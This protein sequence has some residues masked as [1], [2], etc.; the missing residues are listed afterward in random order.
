MLCCF[1]N[2][3]FRGVITNKHTYDSNPNTFSRTQTHTHTDETLTYTKLPYKQHTHFCGSFCYYQENISNFARETRRINA[4]R[5]YEFVLLQIYRYEVYVI[6]CWKCNFPPLRPS[7]GRLVF[8]SVS[9]S[10]NIPNML[11]Y[12]FQ[13]SYRS[14]LSIKF[15]AKTAY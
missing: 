10:V 4:H 2:N 7:A 11:P 6:Y 14:T 12:I 3:D 1:Q 13:R 8:W 15:L 5:Q 9:W